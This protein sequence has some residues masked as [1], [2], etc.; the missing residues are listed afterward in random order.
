MLWVVKSLQVVRPLWAMTP[1]ED[2]AFDVT[3][4]LDNNA[5]VADWH[6]EN[7]S[8]SALCPIPS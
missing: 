2:A 7:V 1:D 6:F 4:M 5:E 3:V 8:S